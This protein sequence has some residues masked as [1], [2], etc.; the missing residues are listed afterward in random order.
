MEAS[1]FAQGSEKGLFGGLDLDKADRVGEGGQ[2]N[3]M[4][5]IDKSESK[6]C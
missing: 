1:R 6:I 2:E 4:V 3:V 5:N